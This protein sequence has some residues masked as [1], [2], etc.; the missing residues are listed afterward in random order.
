MIVNIDRNP[1]LSLYYLG[2]IILHQLLE[3]NSDGIE[4]L[5]RKCQT[6]VN[7]ELPVDF[8]YYALDWLFLASMVY[9][10]NGKVSLCVS[11]S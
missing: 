1:D 8:F 10:E 5:Y 11:K 9:F 3:C 2:G 7:Q 4:N 6:Q